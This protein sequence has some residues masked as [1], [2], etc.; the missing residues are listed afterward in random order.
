M[1]R[2]NGGEAAAH[3]RPLP[4]PP[5]HPM[6]RG[7][8]GGEVCQLVSE[9][10]A[11]PIPPEF[12]FR[13]RQPEVRR[14]LPAMTVGHYARG[15]IVGLTP[16]ELRFTFRRGSRREAN[17]QLPGICTKPAD[18]GWYLGPRR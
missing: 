6:G 12:W 5:L 10:A 2:G 13:L 11:P 17:F 9:S 1:G 15:A 16:Y 18:L 14:A 8:G 4:W 7:N 3:A